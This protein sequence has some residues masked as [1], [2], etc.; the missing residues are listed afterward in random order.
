L[1]E[2]GKLDLQRPVL[3]YLPWLPIV[4]SY[5][6]LSAHHLLTH[7]S[8]LRNALSLTSDR[9]TRYQQA[10]KPG[11]RFYY[12]NLGFDILGHLIELLDGRSWPAAL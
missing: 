2:Q 3:D 8:G 6:A 4:T 9:V 10:W 1:H 7:T 5:G 11:E 12:C